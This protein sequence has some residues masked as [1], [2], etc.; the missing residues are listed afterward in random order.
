MHVVVDN[1]VARINGN[2]LVAGDVG[3]VASASRIIVVAI[4]IAALKGRR[5]WRVWQKYSSG[6]TPPNRTPLSLQIHV[7]ACFY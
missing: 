1:N 7:A 3:E 2:E 4:H 6:H 5:V